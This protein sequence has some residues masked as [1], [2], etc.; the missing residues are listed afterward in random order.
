MLNAHLKAHTTDLNELEQESREAFKAATDSEWEREVKA[1]YKEKIDAVKEEWE[2][3]NAEDIREWIGE[4]KNDPT[5]MAIAERIGYD[6]TGRKDPINDLDMICD[7]Y[8]RFC[9]ERP[10]FFA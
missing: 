2:G 9:V 6:A 1:E 7:E 5:F 4:N 10:D 8:Q 3:Q